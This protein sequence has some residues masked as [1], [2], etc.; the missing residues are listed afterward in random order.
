MSVRQVAILS[1]IYHA[2]EEGITQTEIA[3]QLEIPQAAVSRNIK[4]LSR[5]ATAAKDEDPEI[6][7]HD[8]ISCRPDLYEARRLNCIL[9]KRGRILMDKV[10]KCFAE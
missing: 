10:L 8:L 1:V 6:K 9:T 4:T 5:F 7:G 3:E 2:G